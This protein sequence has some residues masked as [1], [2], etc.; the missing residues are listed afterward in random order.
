MEG[1][2]IV[3]LV[4]GMVASEHGPQ[5]GIALVTGLLSLV[6]AAMFLLVSSISATVLPPLRCSCSRSRN[7]VGGCE[8]SP[9]RCRRPR[10]AGSRIPRAQCGDKRAP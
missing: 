9:R 4:G 3:S 7:R 2:F 6:L 5:L 10:P 1:L 8:E